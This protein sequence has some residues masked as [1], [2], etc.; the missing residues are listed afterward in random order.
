MNKTE[1]KKK[2]IHDKF[3][4]TLELYKERHDKLLLKSLNMEL[5]GQDYANLFNDIIV[6]TPTEKRI[7]A[8]N[9]ILKLV[10]I[11]ICLRLA[12]PYKLQHPKTNEDY[13]NLYTNL[14]T[15][16]DN[17]RGQTI[18]SDIM[19]FSFK[20]KKKECPVFKTPSQ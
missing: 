2:K 3:K 7:L 13:E 16:I 10:N 6:F 9:F 8:L 14:K 18:R 5:G 12:K 11:I 19:L 20:A 17:Y 1:K 15:Y 4:G